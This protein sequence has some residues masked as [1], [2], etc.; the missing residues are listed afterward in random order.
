[1]KSEKVEEATPVA[2]LASSQ[3]FGFLQ[4]MTDWSINR[5]VGTKQ[6]EIVEISLKKNAQ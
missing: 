3:R 1:M 6:A 5:F 4:Y 2:R